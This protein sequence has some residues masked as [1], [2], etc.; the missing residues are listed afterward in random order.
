VLEIRAAIRQHVAVKPH[1]ARDAQTAF[2]QRMRAIEFNAGGAARIGFDQRAQARLLAGQ[3]QRIIDHDFS[4]QE[5]HRKFVA[6]VPLL[7]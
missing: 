1:A 3:A 5:N 7:Y 4:A 6:E 2:D